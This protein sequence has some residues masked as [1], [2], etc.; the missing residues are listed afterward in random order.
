MNNAQHNL[1]V[2]LLC[3]YAKDNGLYANWIDALPYETCIVEEC[4]SD[5]LPPDDCGLVVTHEHYRWEEINALRRIYEQQ[6][7]PILILADG[8]LEY[9]NTWDNPTIPSGSIYQPLMGHK[10]ACIGSSSARLIEA[11]GNGGKVEVVGLPRLDE[12][13]GEQPDLPIENNILITTATTPAFTDDQRQKVVESIRDLKAAFDEGLEFDG[14]P[15]SATWRLTDGLYAEIEMEDPG[16]DQPML[17]DAIRN[18]RAVIT[19]PSTIYLESALLDRPTAILDYSNSPAMAPSV[20]TIGSQANIQNVVSE[21]LRPPAAKKWLQ[22]FY[23]HDNLACQSPA[24]ARM[25]QLV[26]QMVLIGTEQRDNKKPIVLP[27]R[28]LD[29]ETLQNSYDAGACYEDL[30]SSSDFQMKRLQL[31]L[32]EAVHRLGTVPRELADKNIQITQLQ[33]ALDESRRRVADV[34]ARLFK[35]RKILGIGKENQKEEVA[36]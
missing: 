16:E 7:V 6:L 1:K 15:V 3:R 25:V 26:D 32:S 36:D 2:Y 17:L 35:L 23:L 10:I 11:W 30:N 14:K 9:R 24:S 27:E 33:A 21:L 34:R 31:E 5:W 12:L 4:A 29:L 13:I 28:I 19:T 20:W 8:V 22:D 18:S